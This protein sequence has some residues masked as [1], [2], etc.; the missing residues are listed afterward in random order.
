MHWLN[1]SFHG[2]ILFC[3]CYLMVFLCLLVDTFVI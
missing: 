3:V 1:D 2:D